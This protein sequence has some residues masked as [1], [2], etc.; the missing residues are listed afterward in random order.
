[1]P[2]YSQAKIYK[3]TNDY[4]DEVYVGSTYDTLVKRYS[5]HKSDAKKNLKLSPLYKLMNE[6][7]FERFRIELI[8][9]Y[10]CQD[11][12]QLRQREG[13]YIREMGTLNMLIAGRTQI[14]YVKESKDKILEYQRE[15][16]QENRMQE[17]ARHKE[18]RKNNVEKIKEH[19]KTNKEVIQKY[20]IEYYEKNKDKVLKQAAQ[21]VECECGCM[22]RRDGLLDHKKSKKHIEAIKI[23]KQ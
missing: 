1:M 4:N 13:Y 10:S 20:K 5:A 9:N 15:K 16:Y 22:I 2:D 23:T 12:Y 18:Y 11:K 21:K 8:E 17:L 3:I 14:E 7:G 19:Y 6:I